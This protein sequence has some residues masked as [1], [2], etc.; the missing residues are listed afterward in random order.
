MCLLFAVLARVSSCVVALGRSLGSSGFFGVFS[1][2]CDLFFR[3][4]VLVFGGRG[5]L[6]LVRVLGVSLVVGS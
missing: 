5:E 2:C 6:G 3:S 4:L 1:D